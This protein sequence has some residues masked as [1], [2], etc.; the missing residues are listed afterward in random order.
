MMRL[1]YKVLVIA[2]VTVCHGAAMAV[3]ATQAPDAREWSEQLDRSRLRALK[4]PT[5]MLVL[6]TLAKDDSGKLKAS[7]LEFK[8]DFCM[9][10]S[11]IR[12]VSGS[13]FGYAM[14]INKFDARVKDVD[15]ARLADA[16]VLVHPDGESVY[17]V[18]SFTGQRVSVDRLKKIGK[19]L[20]ARRLIDRTLYSLG[21]DGVVLDVKGSHLLVGTLDIRLRKKDLQGLLIKGSSDLM[22]IKTESAREGA[23][24]LTMMNQY[25]G[26]AVFKSIIGTDDV[27]PGQK[28][29]IEGIR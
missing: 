29:I 19:T 22:I 2:S 24:L 18:D 3:E 28:V 4:A 20:D 14:K 5:S 16:R 15:F 6:E 8:N 9:E 23:A 12:C 27:K 26:Y 25:A 11:F 7:S 17:L 21:Y 13:D 10:V 1:A